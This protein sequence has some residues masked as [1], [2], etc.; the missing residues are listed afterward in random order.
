V[1]RTPAA[2]NLHSIISSYRVVVVVVVVVAVSCQ[3]AGFSSDEVLLTN[4]G[5]QKAEN[6]VVRKV[7]FNKSRQDQTLF[8]RSTEKF[9]RL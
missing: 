8:K 4:A 3:K 1:F 7:I 5:T 6:I 9:Y 2:T